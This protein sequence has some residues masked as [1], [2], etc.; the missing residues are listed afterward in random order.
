M[1][2]LFLFFEWLG[3]FMEER[4]GVGLA[5]GIYREVFYF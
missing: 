3:G 1:F 4:F 5:G 2:L